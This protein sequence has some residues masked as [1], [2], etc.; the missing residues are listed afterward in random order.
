MLPGRIRAHISDA[1][2]R[3]ELSRETA[4]CDD[5]A[6]VL[7]TGPE[8]FAVEAFEIRPVVGQEDPVRI[9]GSL[10]L[11]FIGPPE[12]PGSRVVVTGKPRARSIAASATETSSSQ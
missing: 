10:Q 12:M 3:R 8:P 2:V 7:P 5:D 6:R 1:L 11:L 4:P 9:G